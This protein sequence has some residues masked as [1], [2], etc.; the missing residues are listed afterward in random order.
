MGRAKV[1]ERDGYQTLREAIVSGELQPNERLVEAELGA[2]YG[3]GRAAIRGA[4]ARLEQE[5]LI[6]R[7]RHRGAKVRL[8]SQ[9]E[10]VEILEARAALEALAVR[11]TAQHATNAEV[12]E[13]RGMV[14]EMRRLLDSG[15]LLRVSEVNGRLHRRMLELSGHRTAIRLCATL[16]S[17]VVRFQFRT[18]LVPGRPERSFAEHTAVVDAIAA[19]DP[20]A[21]ERAL[22]THLHHVAEALRTGTALAQREAQ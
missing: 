4:F 10:A 12:Q 19:H 21:A 16:A 7:E 13:L 2:T 1:S 5:G 8:V 20:D 3:L 17:Q 11:H 18:I 15:D 9:S 6:L 22:R 14:A